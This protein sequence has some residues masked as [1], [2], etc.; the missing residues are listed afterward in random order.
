MYCIKQIPFIYRIPS[1]THVTYIKKLSNTTYF[2]IIQLPPQNILHFSIF[3]Q[4]FQTHYHF[5]NIR[6]KKCTCSTPNCIHLC[7]ATIIY[8]HYLTLLLLRYIHKNYIYPIPIY[9]IQQ[10][11]VPKPIVFSTPLTT[12]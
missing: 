2:N 8:N 11:L 9:M 7:Q 6:E 1:S 12:I 10:Y 5:V 3:R 4:C